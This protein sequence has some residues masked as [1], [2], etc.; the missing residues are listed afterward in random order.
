MALSHTPR[1]ARAAT[2]ASNV[3]VVVTWSLTSVALTS[4]L[5]SPVDVDGDGDVDLAVNVDGG[6]TQDIADTFSDLHAPTGVAS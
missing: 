1:F 4:S 6:G 5:T 2:L 3:D